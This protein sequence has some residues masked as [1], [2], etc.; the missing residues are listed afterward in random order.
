MFDSLD[1]PCVGLV[2][3]LVVGEEDGARARFA[4]G[5]DAGDARPGP[6]AVDGDADRVGVAQVQFEEAAALHDVAQL[7]FLVAVEQRRRFR[8]DAV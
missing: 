3:V 1:D 2:L 5:Q 8:Y 7:P 4:D 6:V